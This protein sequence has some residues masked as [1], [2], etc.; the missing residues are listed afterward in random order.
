MADTKLVFPSAEWIAKYWELLKANKAYKEAAATWEGDFIFQINADGKLIKDPIMFYM[1]LWH[2]ECRN[3]R[4]A[5]PGERAAFVYAGPYENWKQLFAGKIDPIK[6]LMAN[7]FKLTGDMG[8]V[9][10]ATK[11]AAELV[12]TAVRVPTRFLDEK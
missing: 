11:A 9:M 8:K 3:A 1:D 2:G 10:R 4:M 6:G 5:K 7:K 12:A